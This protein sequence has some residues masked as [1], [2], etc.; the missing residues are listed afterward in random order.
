M[1]E[2]FIVRPEATPNPQT[3][4]FV[5]SKAITDTPTEY[6]SPNETL[7]SPLAR[8]LFGFPWT[9]GVFIGREF[10]A[11]SKQDWVDW[12]TLAEPLADLIQEHLERGEPV[13]IQPEAKTD[14]GNGASTDSNFGGGGKSNDSDSPD[15]K[16]IKKILNDEIRPAVAMD[17]GDVVF[18][19]FENGVVYLFMRG[20]CS[21]CP[22]AS[23][24]LKM[25]IEARLVA[26]V[27]AVKE[28][29]AV[30]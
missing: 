28:V 4:R 23:M 11:V 9:T 6:K 22:S 17:G 21:G 8:K 30:N 15:V 1:S 18:H 2:S 19:K 14:G 20:A 25:G 26:V 10:V 7:L 5:T 16:M 13:I 29:V 24:T 12:E 27:P 3:L